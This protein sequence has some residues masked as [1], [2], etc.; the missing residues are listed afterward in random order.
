MLIVVLICNGPEMEFL[1]EC[2][3]AR[4]RSGCSLNP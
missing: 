4:T 2:F 3:N 1:L